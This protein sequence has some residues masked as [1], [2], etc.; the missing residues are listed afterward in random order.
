MVLD[1]GLIGQK[2]NLQTADYR[3][4]GSH[5]AENI[6]T[7]ETSAANTWQLIHIVTAGKTF[8]ISAVI[9]TTAGTPRFASLG[10]GEPAAEVTI[11]KINMTNG[12]EH[13]IMELPTPIKFTSAT[14]IS[15]RYS[16]ADITTYSLIG[17]E[18]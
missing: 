6:K 5:Q 2:D 1:F 8:Y 4:A 3:S 16:G 9:F 12:N 10:T 13:F 18:E 17:W 15:V 14:K 11:M 7:T